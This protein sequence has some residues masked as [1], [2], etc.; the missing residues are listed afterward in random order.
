LDTKIK[1]EGEDPDKI[2]IATWN[3]YLIHIRHFLRWLHNCAATKNDR[4]SS[5]SIPES[6]SNS[7]WET[8]PAARIKKKRTKRESVH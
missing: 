1:S 5:E 4:D 6:N 2:W 7:D 3:Y 8:P